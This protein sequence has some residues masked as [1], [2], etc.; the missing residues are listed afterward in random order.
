MHVQL[1]PA[2]RHLMEL[3]QS[4]SRLLHICIVLCLMCKVDNTTLISHKRANIMFQYIGMHENNGTLR[5]YL[6]HLVELDK[7]T[8]SPYIPGV[9]S[10]LTPSS[11]KQ[12]S[13]PSKSPNTT[14]AHPWH[15]SYRS[16]WL[17]VFALMTSEQ[18]VHIPNASLTLSAF[19]S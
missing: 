4:L 11:G 16:L 19:L 5:I 18:E 13:R 2:F 12:A 17:L 6:S 14:I 10:I 7:M 15:T 8:G 3:P 1:L 9:Q